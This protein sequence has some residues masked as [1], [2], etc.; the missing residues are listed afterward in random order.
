MEEGEGRWRRG[1]GGGDGHVGRRSC[2][3]AAWTQSGGPGN[4][5]GWPCQAGSVSGVAE[6]R[7]Q[8]TTLKTRAVSPGLPRSPRVLRGENAVTHSTGMRGWG[9]AWVLAFSCAPGP[10]R[11]GAGDAGASVCAGSGPGRVWGLGRRQACS[12]SDV[13]ALGAIGSGGEPCWWAHTSSEGRNCC[14]ETCCAETCCPCAT[15][16]RG[17]SL[18]QDD[19][20]GMRAQAGLLETRL[21]GEAA[22]RQHGRPRAGRRA[23]GAVYRAGAGESGAGNMAAAPL[24][25]QLTARERHFE[26]S[27]TTWW[28]L[29]SG[30]SEV[31][32]FTRPLSSRPSSGGGRSRGT[33]PRPPTGRGGTRRPG[34]ETWVTRELQGQGPSDPPI[35]EKA[36][37]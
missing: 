14:A 10:G 15:G 19:F 17:K 20:P 22:R 6:R 11:L 2:L 16:F 27:G 9:G 36:A 7:G 24:R 23:A 33:V 28:L 34:P 29:S 37:P 13:G 30:S 12:R 35:L 25:Q 26:A 21:G 5:S 4:A 32:G 8:A 31:P 18:V 1:S 3:C